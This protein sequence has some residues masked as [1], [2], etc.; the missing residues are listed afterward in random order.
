M[1][2]RFGYEIHVENPAFANAEVGFAAQKYAEGRNGAFVDAGDNEHIRDRLCEECPAVRYCGAVAAGVVTAYP[3]KIVPRTDHATLAEK[4]ILVDRHGDQICAIDFVRKAVVAQQRGTFMIGSGD[5][6]AS[7]SQGHKAVDTVR[8][9]VA[10][11][12][13][14]LKRGIRL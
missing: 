7:S 5:M 9:G 11:T 14:A 13:A 10:D 2:D 4:G 8:Q 1:S 6:L 3:D 12:M